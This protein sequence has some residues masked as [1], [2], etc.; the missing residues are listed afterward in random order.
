[1]GIAYSLYG[2]IESACLIYTIIVYSIYVNA[3]SPPVSYAAYLQVGLMIIA[4]LNVFGLIVQ[5]YQLNYD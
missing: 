5:T 2:F 3:E 4:A 1:M